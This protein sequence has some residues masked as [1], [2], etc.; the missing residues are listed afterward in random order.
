M[1]HIHKKRPNTRLQIIQLAA[2]LFI[3]EGYQN[4]SIAKLAKILDL[5]PGNITFY[6]KSKEHMLAVLVD[7]QIDFQRLMMEQAAD[8][9]TSSLLAYCLELAAMAA[10]C[11]EDAAAKEYFTAA[12]TSGLTLKLIRKSD[13]EKTKAVFGNYCPHWTQ[14]L[15]AATENIASGIEY[16]TIMTKE[17]EIPLPMQIERALNSIMLLYDVPEDL[18]RSKIQKVLSMD[19]RALGRKILADFKQYI[20]EVNEQNLKNASA[21]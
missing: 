5:S 11:E 3:D 15:W 16:A 18:R 13:T 7:E 21:E 9:G 14:E 6:F 10:I 19:Y 1:S 2:R 8:E 4:T 12:Y 20:S 17:T